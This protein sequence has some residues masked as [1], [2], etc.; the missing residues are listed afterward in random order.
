MVQYL[1]AHVR[2]GALLQ[3][4]EVRRGKFLAEEC[5]TGSMLAARFHKITRR[6]KYMLFHADKGVL[7]GHNKFTGYWEHS[8]NPWTFDYLEFKRQP[9]ENDVR[10]VLH[11]EEA[12]GRKTQLKYHD[13]RM[14]GL[15]KWYP[16]VRDTAVIPE[17]QRLGPDVVLTPFTDRESMRGKVWSLEVFGEA[18]ATDKPI[19]QVL[20]DQSRQAGIGNIYCCESLWHVKLS[21][22]CPASKVPA[23]QVAHLYNTVLHL[24]DVAIH[25]K[26]RYDKYIKV[27]RVKQCSRCGTAIVRGE[28][29]KRGTYYCPTCQG[30]PLT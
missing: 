19:K 21:P 4:I 17:L 8:D 10:V 3:D 14:L 13:M 18:C 6:S 9:T 2:S 23:P 28:L 26:V 27:F 11:L 16:G 22:W 24:M 30:G 7:L 29:Q 15:M 25:H 12:D 5:A 20:L 1:S